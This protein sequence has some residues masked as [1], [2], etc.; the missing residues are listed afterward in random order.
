MYKPKESKPSSAQWERLYA[1][2]HEIYMMKPWQWMYDKDI[3]ALSDPTSPDYIYVSVMGRNGE[4]FAIGAYIGVKGFA[5][6]D[7]LFR[8]GG[9]SNDPSEFRTADLL[10]TQTC[11]QV[12]FYPPHTVD[13]DDAKRAVEYG[14]VERE[15]IPEFRSFIPTFVPWSITKEEATQLIA[16]LEQ[17]I[18]VAPRFKENNNLFDHIAD[19]RIFARVCQPANPVCIWNDA[20]IPLPPLQSPVE[21][22]NSEVTAK[23]REYMTLLSD[24]SVT[25]TVWECGVDFA[26]TPIDGRPYIL[27]PYFPKLVLLADHTTNFIY[28]MRLLDHTNHSEQ[29]ATMMVTS[30]QKAGFIPKK[31]LVADAS[32]DIVLRQLVQDTQ[33]D[34]GLSFDLPAVDEAIAHMD[35]HMDGI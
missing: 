35:E 22:L 13:A 20:D 17:T 9:M 3:F 16:T 27:R 4:H 10:N 6:L 8:M 14:W 7:M 32:L 34:I 29:L 1:L 26:S 2:S 28:G 23:A 21:M 25:D 15:M 19:D 30:C 33:I 12:S 24:F 31:I 11:V 5:G 18:D